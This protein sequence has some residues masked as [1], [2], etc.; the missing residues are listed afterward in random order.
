MYL[1]EN[2]LLGVLE[3]LKSLN[4]LAVYYWGNGITAGVS[5]KKVEARARGCKHEL[6]KEAF[7]W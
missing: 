4:P 3:D 5:F 6:F 1:A 7:H 2:V